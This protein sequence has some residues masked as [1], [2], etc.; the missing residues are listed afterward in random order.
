MF[1]PGPKL[2][3]CLEVLRRANLEARLL[4]L[5]GEQEGLSRGDAKQLGDLMDAVHNLPQLAA[6]W[7]RCNEELLRE[8][9]RGYDERY[10]FAL[11]D[12]YDRTVASHSRP[13]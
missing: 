8:M 3:A 12:T 10:G 11:P 4:G 6:D 9:L 1:A 13:A 5:R 7:G 2:A